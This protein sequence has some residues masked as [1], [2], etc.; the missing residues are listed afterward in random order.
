MSRASVVALLSVLALV[1][2]T[3]A[4]Q[5]IILN[6]SFENTV[7]DEEDPNIILVADWG[8]NFNAS[9]SDD[10]AFEGDWSALGDKSVSSFC[11]FAQRTPIEVTGNTRLFMQ[12]LVYNPSSH[13]LT[14][15]EAAGIKIE[16]RP[17]EG[18][19]LPP[20]E[21]NLIFDANAP[22]DTWEL[23]TYSTVVPADVFIAEIVFLSF[24]NSDTNGAVYCDSVFAERGSAPGS[25]Q[26]LNNSFEIG[27]NANDGLTFW[28]EFG[29][30]TATSRKNNG[31]VPAHAGAFVCKMDGNT[32]GV[33]QPIDVAPGET[34]DIGGY[35]RQRSA[36]P[37]ADPDAFAG[38]KVQWEAGAIPPQVDIRAGN[39]NPQSGV[40]NIVEEGA[41]TDQWVTVFID[42][43]MPADAAAALTGTVINGFA[44]GGTPSKCYFDAVEFVLTNIFTG[45]DSD[46]DSDQDI[47]DIAL[48]QQV[49]TGPGGPNVYG[50][51]VFDHDEDDDVD[52]TDVG[53]NVL[54][55][56]TNPVVEVPEEG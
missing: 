35:F 26:L 41:P 18:L 37:Y 54:P 43:T 53:T 25:N 50:G 48:L 44:P 1:V 16:F 39:G 10:F 3:Q 31:E 29:S 42:Y 36:N 40:N 49:F 4:R 2:T 45:S 8:I 46:A 19:V 15:N 38:P 23:V 5:Q 51:L 11:G 7:P 14:S 28:D 30:A 20:P 32:T 47:A 33:I 52:W 56:M 6:G 13:P 9:R 34:L 17:P 21:E 22:V 55:N 12:A 24:D 27:I